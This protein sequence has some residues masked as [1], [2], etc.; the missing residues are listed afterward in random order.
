[1]KV[2]IPLSERR[3]DILFIAFFILNLS[4]ITYFV[5]DR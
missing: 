5:A 4:F 3:I 1:M 2:S